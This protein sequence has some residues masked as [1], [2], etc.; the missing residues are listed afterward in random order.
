MARDLAAA[1]AHR[2]RI[3]LEDIR[4]VIWR[5]LLVPSD[6]TLAKLHAAIQAAFPW[7]NSHLHLFEVQGERF[8]D[9][10]FELDYVEGDE[11]KVT[12]AQA[13]PRVGDRFT[14]EYDFGDSWSH[15]IRVSAIEPL[16]ADGAAPRMMCVGGARACPPDDCGGTGG[17][18][19][20]VLAL[21]DPKHERHDELISW[22]TEWRAELAGGDRRFEGPF[23]PEAF[24]LEAANKAVGKLTRRKRK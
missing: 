16:P 13:A 4:P 18:E 11:R 15:Q 12:I 2:L 8:S 1:T 24:D 21:A 22:L 5:E 3:E 20:L 23:D 14:Y 9:P 10:G 7:T 17:Y 19:E 6:T